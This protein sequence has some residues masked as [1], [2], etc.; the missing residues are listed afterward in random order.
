MQIDKCLRFSCSE[1]ISIE[2][3]KTKK[4]CDTFHSQK[5]DTSQSESI[6]FRFFLQPLFFVY[7]IN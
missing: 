4:L 3:K 6:S 1:L 5:G 7:H 2:Q